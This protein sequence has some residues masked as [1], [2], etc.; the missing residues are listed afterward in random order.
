M[1][2]YRAKLVG[3][4]SLGTMTIQCPGAVIFILALAGREGVNW[5]SWLPYAVT[6]G[7]QGALL[8][9]QCWRWRG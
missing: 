4:L 8:V 5:T 2:T 3:A 1:K 6:A 9:S 7:M